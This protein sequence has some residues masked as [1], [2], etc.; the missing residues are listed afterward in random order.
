[1]SG[2]DPLTLP[3]ATVGAKGVVSV[4]SNLLPDRVA[5]LCNAFLSG[6]W[7]T[8]RT[9]NNGLLPIARSMLTLDTNPIPIKTA[10]HLAGRDTGTLRLPLCPPNERAMETLRQLVG[11]CDL[12]PA[13]AI[14]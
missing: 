2:D 8:A 5:A 10:M 9:I 1:M 7:D 13:E 4:L 14:A 12:Q 11:A 3:L 6:D